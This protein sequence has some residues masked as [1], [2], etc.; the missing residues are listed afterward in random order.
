MME[1][2]MVKRFSAFSIFFL[3][4]E[5]NICAQCSSIDGEL[6]DRHKPAVLLVILARNKAHT[7]PQYLGFIDNLDYPKDRISLWVRADHSIDNTS[8][9]LREWVNGAGPL[10]HSY[11]MRFDDSPS[12][13]ADEIG[14]MDWPESRYYHIINLREEALNA[15]RR[16]WADYAFF[17]DSDNF[18]EYEDTLNELIKQERLLVAPMLESSTAFSNFWCGQDENGYYKR[19]E[20]YLPTLQRERLGCF[21]VPMIHSTFLIDLRQRKSDS[22]TFNPNKLKDYKHAVD[23]IIIFAQSA[24]D[25]GIP[26]Y[27]CNHKE[28]GH[29]SVP[30]QP[31]E[32]L[33]YDEECFANLKLDAMTQYSQ[34]EYRWNKTRKHYGEAEPMLVSKYVTVPEKTKDSLGFD[35][36]FLI[37]LLRRPFRRRRM[38]ASLAELR[39][40]AAIVDAT[41][42][43]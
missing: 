2:R 40:D 23:D 41:D 15:A 3:L 5:M 39:V 33:E 18:L 42:G 9:V 31:R 7:L 19:T 8:A 22:L 35:K 1:E 4:L 38:L 20:E 26:M 10:Y 34:W 14:P 36:V 12:F 17:V 25:A 37:N 27:I 43:K 32:T 13:F 30:R 11:D 21:H 24:R 16:M 29:M 6:G 28:F